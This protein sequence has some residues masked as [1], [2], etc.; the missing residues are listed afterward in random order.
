[1]DILYKLPLPQELCNKIFRFAC[2]S[3]HTD[4]GSAILKNLIGLYIYNKLVERG[5]IVLDGDGNVVE[6]RS[7]AG[8]T[9]Y[10]NK[11]KMTFDIARLMSLP[12]LTMINLSGTSVVGDIA[13]LKSLPNLN[14]IVLQNT[15]VVGDIAHLNLMPKLTMI[16]LYRT[17][18]SGH[19]THLTSL[20]NL[21]SIEI[22]YTHVEGKSSEFRNYRKSAG[23][24]KCH[25]YFNHL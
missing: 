20:P 2:K 8:C 1:M 15:S 10:E 11:N 22:C 21:R 4:L 7:T 5:G 9:N 25:I 17:G 16:D 13:H 3:P 19:I 23:L 18:V 12:K 24:K 14:K 6:F